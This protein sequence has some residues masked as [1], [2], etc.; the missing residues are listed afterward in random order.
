[1][2]V[3]FTQFSVFN[4]NSPA[5]RKQ[6]CEEIENAGLEYVLGA[7]AYKLRTKYPQLGCKTKDIE[8][9]NPTSKIL[10]YPNRVLTVSKG[11]LTYPSDDLIHVG[12]I[13]EEEFKKFHGKG[14]TIS[15]Q[16]F[17]YHRVAKRVLIKCHNIPDISFEVIL[18][19]VK[20][21]TRIRMYEIKKNDKTV[22]N[23]E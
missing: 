21:R 8:T 3:F 18:E 1:M 11:Y 5:F 13:T 22:C 19:I 10:S 15:R 14:L 16:K 17:I 23:K 2:Y 7:I 4:K 20:T 9:L 12:R 6:I